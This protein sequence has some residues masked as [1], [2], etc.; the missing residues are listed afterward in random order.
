M[1]E[2][3]RIWDEIY[4]SGH[5]NRYPWD[6]VVTFVFRHGTRG[7]DRKNCRILE[8][9]CGAANN[10]W[11]AAREGFQVIGIDASK[12][13][14]EWAKKRFDEEGLLGEFIHGSFTDIP[15]SDASID[16]VIDR[17]SLT[18]TPMPVMQAAI[19]E[20]Y[21]V[22]KPGGRMLF[23]PYADSHSSYMAGDFVADGQVTNIK[24]G[25]LVQVGQIT[26]CSLESIRTLFSKG[27]EIETVQRSENIDMIKLNRHIHAEYR[28]IAK[29]L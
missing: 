28:V 17:A 16:L 23:V 3:D 27:W 14:I 21:R 19:Y 11:F 26:F 6:T 10:L 22:L 13:A 15:L 1:K 2:F 5:V 20:A 25:T 24:G 9:G 29:K 4:Q 12:D 7:D 18:C 8:L